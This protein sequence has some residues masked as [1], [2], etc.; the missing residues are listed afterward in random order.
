MDRPKSLDRIFEKK[1]FRIPDY[2]RGYAWRPIQLEAF[3]ED[4]VNLTDDRSHYTGV[5]TLRQV[6]RD[7]V[8]SQSKEFWLVDDHS[9]E[10][11]HIVDGQQRLTTS[12]ILIQAF[13]EVFRSHSA[14]NG[15]PD[16]H[17]YVTESLS[18]QDI[19]DRYLFRTKPTGDQFRTYLFGYEEDN[20]S[21]EYLRYR[22]FAE[23]GQGTVH[24]TFY[25]LNLDVAKNYF[26]GQLNELFRQEGSAGLQQLYRRL[27][28]NFHFNEYVIEDEFDVFVAFET[29]NNRGKKLSDLELLKNRLIYLTTLYGD[30][31]LDPAERKNLRV[32]INAAW[33]EV[34]YQLGRNRR[35][36]LNDDDFLRAHWVMYYKYSRK[37]G[38]DY[39]KFLLDEQFAP[40][41]V[42][43]KI[44]VTIALES[45]EE[46]KDDINDVTDEEA[47]EEDQ[48][49]PGIVNEEAELKPTQIR[50]YVNSLKQSAVH[51]FISFFPDQVD[52]ISDTDRKW[53]DRLHRIGIV[54]FRPL[55]MA[56]LKSSWSQEDRE[57]TFCEIERFIFL[58]FRINQAR[59]THG[60][61]DFYNFARSVDRG[62]ATAEDIIE[63][64]RY[65]LSYSMNDDGSFRENSFYNNAYKW[66]RSGTGY[67]SWSSLRYFLYEY[68]LSLLTE[69]RHKKVDWS[70][71]LRSERDR[72]SIEHIYPQT[73]T[74]EWESAFRE[75]PEDLRSRYQGSLGNLLLLS[76]SINSSLQNDSFENKKQPR[77]DSDGTKIRNG[78]ADG[79]HSEIQ[80]AQNVTW[81]PVEIRDRGLKLLRFMEHRWGIRFSSAETMERLLFLDGSDSSENGV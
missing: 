50:D 31:E 9:F 51:W 35:H 70:D 27:T 23:E 14:N 36:P 54:Y 76:Q 69:S 42:H 74:P 49:A 56:V 41:R 61:S 64:L 16:D 80:V 32:T 43:K 10:L 12:I 72:I 47:P 24:E 40:K 63:R 13:L 38:S 26:V 48:T 78:Y 67:Y 45:P 15:T 20:P 59:G 39:I 29:M 65:R 68:E 8:D 25:T 5:L 18:I 57:K 6:D 73:G 46:L 55:V 33:K 62:E 79:S 2:Q 60:S 75:I 1:I 34:Y 44:P 58:D 4:L 77:F 66:F 53:I 28:K 37:T 30:D 81:G 71:L 3:W 21:H 7:L 17:I 22:V 52:S 19:R 11:Y